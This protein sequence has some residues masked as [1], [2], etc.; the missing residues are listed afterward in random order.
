MNT[1]INYFYRDFGNNKRHTSI[2]VE[3]LPTGFGDTSPETVLRSAEAKIEGLLSDQLSGDPVNFKPEYLHLPT[4]RFEEYKES[5]SLDHEW[6]EFDDLELTEEEPDVALTADGFL[7]KMELC[8]RSGWSS[9]LP[10][11]DIMPEP[12]PRGIG[13]RS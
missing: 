12:R 2:I 1:Q 5:S 7:E 3:G 9:A 13:M 8:A 11:D 6:H 10:T 4:A